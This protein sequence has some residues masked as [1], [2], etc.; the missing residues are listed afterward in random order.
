MMMEDRRMV[1]RNKIITGIFLA[2]MG[3]PSGSVS[4]AAEGVISKVADANDSYCFLKFPAIKEDTLY[5]DRPV[6]KDPS[7]G[8]IISYYGP[9][10]HDPLG[11]EEIRRQRNQLLE[12]RRR[13]PEGD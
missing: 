6:L 2:A 7:S 4:W 3:L 1:R 13:L 12:R 8:D 10:D 9:C 11:R 5:W